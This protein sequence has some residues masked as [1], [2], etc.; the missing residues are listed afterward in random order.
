MVSFG[1]E[2]ESLPVTGLVRIIKQNSISHWLMSSQTML[3][4]GRVGQTPAGW[5]FTDQGVFFQSDFT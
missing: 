1:V 5:V 4:S 3:R 2:L